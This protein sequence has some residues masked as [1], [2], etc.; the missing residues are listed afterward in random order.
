M[1]TSSPGAV[2]TTG[3]GGCVVPLQAPP[4]LSDDVAGTMPQPKN[5]G[6]PVDAEYCCSTGEKSYI[7]SAP[8]PRLICTRWNQSRAL[9]ALRCTSASATVAGAGM[10]RCA[11]TVTSSI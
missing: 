2:P 5:F 3:L 7:L 4:T 9:L 8:A 6:Q 11:P 1:T 10:V